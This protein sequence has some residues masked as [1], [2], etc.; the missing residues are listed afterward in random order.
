VDVFSSFGDEYED[1]VFAHHPRTGLRTIIAIYSTALGPALG[2]TRFWP[3]RSEDEAFADV[4]RLARAMAYKAA[5]AGLALG[6]GKAVVIG[7]PARD[8]TP[9]LLRAYG[10]AVERLGGRYITTADVGTSTADMD[11]IATATSYVTGTTN[12]SGDPSEVTAYGVWHGMRAVAE[13]A[14]GEPSLAGRTVVVQGVGKVGGALARLLAQE[15]ARVLVS[16]VDRVRAEALCLELSA[17]SVPPGEAVTTPCDVL[18]PCALGPV[19]TEENVKELPCRAIAGAANNQLRSRDLARALGDRGIVYAPD[20]VINAGGLINCEDELH[21]Y[22]RERALGKAAA[23]AATLRAVFG[24]A[25]A[26]GITTAEAA[27]RTAEARIRD[28]KRRPG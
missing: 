17:G 9:E 7:D 24:E 3:F 10:R 20:Y 14:F 27:D 8:K 12:G 25:R 13:E 23:I 2:G 18:A 1:V 21:G 5:A 15:G 4:L 16:D 28:A 26:K 6:G 22:E 11:V 19:V